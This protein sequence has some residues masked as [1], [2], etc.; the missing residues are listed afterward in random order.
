MSSRPVQVL[1]DDIW[2]AVEKIRRYTSGMD[3]QGFMSDEKTS[4]AVIRN[5]EIIGEAANRLPG[6]FVRGHSEVNWRQIVGLR[7]RIVH[8]YFGVDLEIVWSILQSDLPEFRRMLAVLRNS[9]PDE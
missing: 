9:M 1:L 7:H 8:D 2:E 5:L 4:D 3:R 6:E